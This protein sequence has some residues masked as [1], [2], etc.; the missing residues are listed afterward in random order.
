MTAVGREPAQRTL[1]ECMRYLREAA[2]VGLT[3]AAGQLGVH[4]GTLSHAEHGRDPPSPRIIGYYERAFHGD[5]LLWSLYVEARTALRPPPTATRP[6]AVYPLPGDRS[7]FVADVTIPDGTVMPP[8]FAFL[9]VWRLQN[10]GSVTWVGRQIGRRGAASGHGIPHSPMRVAI[11][12]TE[13]GDM[14][15]IVVPMRAPLLPATAQA[16]WKMVDGEGRLYF[17]D[18]YRYGILVTITVQEGALPPITTRGAGQVGDG[19]ATASGPAGEEWSHG[20]RTEQPP[21]VRS[22]PERSR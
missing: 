13:P 16:H 4:P 22:R 17:P 5:G 1:G 9:K 14:V 11:P 3:Q 19:I 8:G 15:D 20:Q 12:R 10:V 7:R 18:R 2:E 6:A 21:G